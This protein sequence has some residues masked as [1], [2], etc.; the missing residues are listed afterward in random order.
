MFAKSI[1]ANIY[2]LEA[3]WTL[4]QPHFHRQ[5]LKAQEILDESSFKVQ[6]NS[7]ISVKNWKF[8]TLKGKFKV[9]M[10]ISEA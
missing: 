5:I 2:D 6:K 10:H 8:W 4:T 9:L 1:Y 7:V 3:E